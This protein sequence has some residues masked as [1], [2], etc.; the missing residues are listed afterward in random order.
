[1]LHFSWWSGEQIFL[2][3]SYPVDRSSISRFVKLVQKTSRPSVDFLSSIGVSRRYLRKIQMP[4]IKTIDR[5]QTLNL[6]ADDGTLIESCL[7]DYLTIVSSQW[8]R[9]STQ[10]KKLEL[11][12]TDTKLVVRWRKVYIGQ[13]WWVADCRQNNSIFASKIIRWSFLKIWLGL[14][15]FDKSRLHITW[16]Y[17]IAKISLIEEKLKSEWRLMKCIVMSIY[18]TLYYNAN[19]FLCPCLW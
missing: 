15:K 18:N 6:F 10:K 2:V 7:T 11:G 9:A 3:S 5:R 19:I 8:N 14:K 4:I 16:N 13:D 1:M 17:F 12:K